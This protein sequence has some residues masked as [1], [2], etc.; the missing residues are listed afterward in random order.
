VKKKEAKSL[1][2]LSFLLNLFFFSLE[3]GV[4]GEKERLE[5]KETYMNA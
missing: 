2:F 1:H 3:D 5:G 4:R